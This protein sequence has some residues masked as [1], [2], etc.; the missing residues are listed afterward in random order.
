MFFPL[1]PDLPD[2]VSCRSIWIFSFFIIRVERIRS[3][4]ESS[5]YGKRIFINWTV[6]SC[7]FEDKKMFCGFPIG[8]IM[9]PRFAARV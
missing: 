3:A 4:R 6:P 2:S 1:Q 9:L 5:V 7:I 8:V